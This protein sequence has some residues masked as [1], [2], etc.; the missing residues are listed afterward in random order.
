MGKNAYLFEKI[1]HKE[2]LVKI[3]NSGEDPGPNFDWL[4]T[5]SMISK[6]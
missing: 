3:S 2:N 4:L 5:A 1:S 6:C